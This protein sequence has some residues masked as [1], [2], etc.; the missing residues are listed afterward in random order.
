MW[1]E[2]VFLVRDSFKSPMLVIF[3]SFLNTGNCPLELHTALNKG[4]KK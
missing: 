1:E 2:E 3:L 4:V